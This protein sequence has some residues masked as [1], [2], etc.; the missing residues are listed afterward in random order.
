MRR[1][2]FF[3][4]RISR[5][6]EIVIV[7]LSV[8]VYI[9]LIILLRG[10]SNIVENGGEF[11]FIFE[12]YALRG[13]LTQLQMMLTIFIVLV[14]YKSGYITA[15][16]LNLFNIMG[17]AFYMS[18]SGS[19]DA[20]PGIITNV[21]TI[22]IV[23]LIMQ[24]KREA[25]THVDYI[26]TQRKRLEIS[27]KKLYDQAFM[28]E[29]TGKPNRFYIM[30]KINEDIERA[31]SKDFKIVVIFID[32]D[33][34]KTINDTLGHL[35][36]DRALLEI[37]NRLDAIL[38]DHHTIG[39]FGGDEFIITCSDVNI[40]SKVEA[41]V[42]DVLAAIAKP[43][44]LNT[45]KFNLTASVG[46]AIYPEG[47]ANS[48]E[49]IVNADMA[50]YEAK[51]QG[52]NRYIYFDNEIRSVINRRNGLINHLHYAIEKDELYLVYQPQINTLTKKM[53]GLEV[54]LRWNNAEYGEVSP[55][56]FI[57]LAERTGLIKQIGL[58]VFE[59]ACLEYQ[60]HRKLHG[61]D[62]K[63]ALNFSIVQIKDKRNIHHLT[64]VLK[65]TN[66]NPNNIE[67]EITEG[68]GFTDETDVIAHLKALQKIGFTIAI[69]DFGKGY[70]SLIRIRHL[71]L[72]LIKIDMEFVQGIG[73]NNRDEEII[74]GII[75]LARS[76]GVGVL[77]EGVE[78]E[79]QYAFL[80]QEECDAIQ[81]FMFYKPMVLA[82]L[83][84]LISLPK[85]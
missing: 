84:P 15:I 37:A 30:K 8:F 60:H 48:E 12:A 61:N 63:L 80:K 42:N 53:I 76:L 32:L 5:K 46:I 62:L 64:E 1:W 54:L 31:K 58:W 55:G 82:E 22:I 38:A 59:K 75:S 50:M 66:M 2:W 19:I 73:G 39:R 81:G 7:S 4:N 40:V 20:M 23:T 10:L 18:Q 72:D 24:Y 13:V 21:A 6:K 77:A 68:I 70:S 29:L 78:V 52:K 51:K 85:E 57:P 41:I 44:Y 27:E 35:A 25:I 14:L 3:Q 34:F 33:S 11:H 28:D 43:I 26:D 65:K 9:M 16:L 71:P 56:E 36:G 83:L 69:D 49:L 45:E 67:I 17:A 74:K 47:G 79:E